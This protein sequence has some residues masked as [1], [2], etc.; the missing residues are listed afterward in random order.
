MKLNNRGNFSL[1]GLL[2]AMVIIVV[3]A[4]I[5]FGKGGGLSTVKSDSKL[6]DQSS[7][8]QTLIGKSLDTGQSVDCR[9]HLRQ[10]RAGISTYKLSSGSDENPAT[11]KD[12]KLGTSVDY[13]KCPVSE[14]AYTY[15]PATGTV[16][17]PTHPSF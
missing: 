14:Q 17:C 8:K 15:N 10:I 2:A 6:L 4:A 16:T 12:I 5:Y 7:K 1:I 13:F 11:L 3:L 9:E